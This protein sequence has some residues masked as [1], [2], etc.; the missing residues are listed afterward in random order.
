MPRPSTGPLDGR[1][2]ARVALAADVDPRTVRR[3]LAGEAVLLITARSIATALK[4]AGHGA[5][6][7]APQT[8]RAA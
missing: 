7:K 1:T 3:Y 5:L 8:E 4:K 6:V 2:L